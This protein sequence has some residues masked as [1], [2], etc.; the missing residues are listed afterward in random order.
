MKVFE[1]QLPGVGRRYQVSF[2][3]GGTFTIVVH[4][5]GSRKVFWRDD[6]DGDSE[7][8]FTAGE[9]DAQKLA[10]IFEGVFFE[11]VADDLDDA[12]SGARVKWVAIPDDSP[13]VGQTIGDVGI[14]T[15]TGIS[16]LAI[17]R[18]DQIIANPTP[19]TQLLAD[20]VIVVVGED[21]AHQE[22][23]TLLSRS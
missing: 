1:T 7:E 8:L 2:P 15:R 20:D 10:E 18:A 13:V 14:R 19:E 16:I 12:L 17:E 5:D 6:P 23:D 21:D 3:D 4:N 11:P 22:L 9:R